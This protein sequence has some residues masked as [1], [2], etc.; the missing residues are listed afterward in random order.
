MKQSKKSCR[1]RP[2]Y[3]RSPRGVRAGPVL[4]R[5]LNC[6][7][8]RPEVERW[9]GPSHRYP[10]YGEGANSLQALSPSSSF[11]TPPSPQLMHTEA[12]MPFP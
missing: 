8:S 12:E 6:G 4:L 5:A 1:G 3:V 2:Q 7:K 9:A 10:G 11:D